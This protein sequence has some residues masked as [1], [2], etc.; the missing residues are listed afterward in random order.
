[1]DFLLR[2]LFKIIFNFK[3]LSLFVVNFSND[4]HIFS[5]SRFLLYT[6]NVYTHSFSLSFFFFFHLVLTVP[7]PIF[8][9]VVQS[10]PFIF[11]LVHAF[12]SCSLALSLPGCASKRLLSLIPS[13]CFFQM[14]ALKV[15][16][17][18]N[19]SLAFCTLSEPIWICNL[20]TKPKN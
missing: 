11:W 5:N 15:P 17:R 13:I 1:M 16:K 9:T 2:L 12:V 7:A 8:S 14:L 18:E 6:R 20:G 3:L 4:N 10:F 19:F